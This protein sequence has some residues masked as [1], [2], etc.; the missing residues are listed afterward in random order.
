MVG[1][2][3]SI[4][5]FFGVYIY[6]V[7]RKGNV[8]WFYMIGKTPSLTKFHNDS[9]VAEDAVPPAGKGG[10]DVRNTPWKINGWV[11]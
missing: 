1:F 7:P 3:F 4:F 10:W 9:K 6:I 2:P 11:P 5:V 8:C